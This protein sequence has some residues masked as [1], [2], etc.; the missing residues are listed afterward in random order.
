MYVKA[1]GLILN[2]IIVAGIPFLVLIAPPALV[3]LVRRARRRS[4]GRCIYCAYPLDGSTT[5]PEC[6]TDY[7][8]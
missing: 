2:P 6:G 7:A 3:M 1:L 5:C 8:P 4:R